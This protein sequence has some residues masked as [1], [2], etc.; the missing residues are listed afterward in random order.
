MVPVSVRPK[1]R[2]VSLIRRINDRIGRS[3]L[4]SNERALATNVVSNMA[5]SNTYGHV[6]RT[7]KRLEAVSKPV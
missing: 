4:W 2:H 7:V 3:G 6:Y 1:K 5:E